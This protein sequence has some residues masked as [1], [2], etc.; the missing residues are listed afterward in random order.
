MR[1]F[2]GKKI[3]VGLHDL[4]SIKDQLEASSDKV[5]FEISSASQPLDE[6]LFL[7][8]L[9]TALQSVIKKSDSY[10]SIDEI[11]RKNFCAFYLSWQ[12]SKIYLK[13]NVIFLLY[14]INLH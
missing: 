2:R 12:V 8:A 14:L 10:G 4:L 5:R 11:V 7:S 1:I 13:M 3:K 9:Y 6:Y